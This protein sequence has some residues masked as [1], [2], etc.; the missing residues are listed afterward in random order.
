MTKFI[1]KNNNFEGNLNKFEQL[2]N[3]ILTLFTNHS[4]FKAVNLFSGVS[5]IVF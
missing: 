2:V 5:V 4:K 1:K 3:I